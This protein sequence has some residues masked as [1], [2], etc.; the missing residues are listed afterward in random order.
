MHEL[1]MVKGILECALKIARE[2]GDLPVECVNIQVGALRQVE[3]EL[4][5]FAFEAAR[6]DTLAQDAALE[7]EEIPALV[8]CGNCRHDYTPSEWF[9]ACPKCD[10]IGGRVLQGDELLVTSVVLCEE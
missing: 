9:W 1:S 6:T 4:L 3:P 5:V 7:W 10:T 8:E 2:H